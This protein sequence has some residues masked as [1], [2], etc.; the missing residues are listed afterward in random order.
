M[1]NGSLKPWTARFHFKQQN[2]V[3]GY[4]GLNSMYCQQQETVV[5]FKFN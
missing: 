2:T 4:L 3:I 5:G 1:I